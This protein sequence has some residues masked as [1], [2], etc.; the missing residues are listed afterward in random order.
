MKPKPSRSWSASR[1]YGNADAGDGA[2]AQRRTPARRRLVLED[3]IFVGMSTLAQVSERSPSYPPR[4]SFPGALSCVSSFRLFEERI[5]VQKWRPGGGCWE[6]SIRTPPIARAVSATTFTAALCQP[7][8][9][10]FSGQSPSLCRL[11]WRVP[12]GGRQVAPFGNK[13]G[14]RSSC[15]LVPVCRNDGN[16]REGRSAEVRW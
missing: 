3:L 7:A 5:G 13:N 12:R 16:G 8:I 6:L 15:S 2:A 11:D 4:S 14:K 1:G 9:G 10:E